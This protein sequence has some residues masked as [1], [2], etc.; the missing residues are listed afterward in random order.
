MKITFWNLV[1]FAPESF[2]ARQ[3]RSETQKK[4]KV[5]N[6]QQILNHISNCFQKIASRLDEQQESIGELL[7]RVTPVEPLPQKQE[8]IYDTQDLCLFLN[9]SKRTIQRHRSLG[10]LPFYKLGRKVFYKE[11]DV[12]EYMDREYQK[13]DKREKLA[14][15]ANY[16][17]SIDD[18]R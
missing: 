16:G 12:R 9:T 18:I 6:E 4:K 5:M 8:R 15:L 17:K 2:Q 10:L 3:N 14:E 1:T 11:Q 13:V 7:Q